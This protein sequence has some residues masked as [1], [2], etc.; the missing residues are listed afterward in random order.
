MAN[1]TKL[2]LGGHHMKQRQKDIIFVCLMLAIPVANFIV[3]W[4]V[5]NYHSIIM[6]FQKPNGD[7]TWDNF[8]RFWRA[9]TDP[10]FDDNVKGDLVNTFILFFWGTFVNMPMVLFMSYIMFKKI[11]GYK[12][13]RVIFYLPSILGATVTAGVFRY[14]VHSGGPIETLLINMDVPIDAQLG[15]LGSGET[16]FTMVIIYSLWTGV[17]SNLIMYTGAMNRVPTD[18]FESAR[19]DG[20]GF[21]REFFQ[22][23]LPLIWPTVTTMLV[24]GMCGIFTNYAATQL[25][26]PNS[27]NSSTIGWYIVRHTTAAGN[28]TTNEVYNYPAAVGL[29]F[30]AVGMPMV[31]GTKWLCEKIARNVEY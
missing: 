23:V 3:Y 17:G 25:L 19:I 28:S 30:T 2:R 13:F 12:I 15:L 29:I 14:F 1:T 31:L 9:L 22:I 11:A 18:I 4:I 6:G 7:F 5:P 26:T 20:V 27:P 10:A 24:S 21:W 8:T 16:A